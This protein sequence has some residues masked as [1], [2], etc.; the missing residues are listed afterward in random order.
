MC[1][2]VCATFVGITNCESCTRPISTNPGSIKRASVGKR[3]GRVS[4]HVVSRWSWS[5]GC[6]GFHGCVFGGAD[7]CVTFFGRFLHR[8]HTACCK[9]EASFLVYLSTDGAVCHEHQRPQP[10]TL[11]VSLICAREA[12]A[13]RTYTNVVLY[14]LSL[15]LINVR[16]GSHAFLGPHY[17][18]P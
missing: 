10:R 2:S 11:A 17:K 18:N 12:V 13:M 1:L 3:M 15:W 6:Y 14:V 4:L 9:Y 7:F 16:C 8:T 5:P